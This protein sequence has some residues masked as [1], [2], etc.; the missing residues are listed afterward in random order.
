MAGTLSAIGEAIALAERAEVDPR[1][2]M[3]VFE[4]GLASSAVLS[5][6]KEKLL[7][8]DYSLG[9]SAANQ[10]KRDLVYASDVPPSGS[11]HTLR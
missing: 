8:G 9:G 3:E 6:K 2:L 10:L 5:L 4:G 1:L 7:D 11:A